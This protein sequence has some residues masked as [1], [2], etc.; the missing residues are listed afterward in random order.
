MINPKP[1]EQADGAYQHATDQ[2][3]I[4]GIMVRFLRVCN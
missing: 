4:L 2:K 3:A 1:M